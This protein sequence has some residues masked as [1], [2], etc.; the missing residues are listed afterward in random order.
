MAGAALTGAMTYA[1]VTRLVQIYGAFAQSARHLFCD[2]GMILQARDDNAPLLARGLD[3]WESEVPL[4]LA[5]TRATGQFAADLS[6]PRNHITIEVDDDNLARDLMYDMR[7]F[8]PF[9]HDRP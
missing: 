4:I 6:L 8:C 3:R 9:Y 1:V 2:P 7:P 5:L